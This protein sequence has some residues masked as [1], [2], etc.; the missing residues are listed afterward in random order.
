MRREAARIAAQTGDP[1]K[2]A[3]AALRLVQ[4][5]IRYVFI[6]LDGG[7]YRPQSA[8]QTWAQRFGDCKA[9]TTLL[10]ALLKELGVPAEAVLVNL[11]GGDGSNERLPSP[12]V[13]NH[14]LVRADI[15][16]KRYWMD[17]VR[18]GDVNL[19][20][21]PPPP[22]LW[23]LPI[24][25]NATLETV[26]LQIPALPLL[27]EK[28]T[29]DTSKGFDVPAGITAEHTMRGDLA[30]KLQ[31]DLAAM[32]PED[33]ERGQ[34]SYWKGEQDWVEPQ[35]VAWRYDEAQKILVLTMSGTGK[36]DWEGDATD[37]HILNI[38]GAGFTPPAEKKRPAE[39][40]QNAPWAL[41]FPRHVCF[42]T[43]I[44]LPAV[45][46]AKWRWTYRS[47]PVNR[48]LGGIRYWRQAAL[49]GDVMRTSM[50]VQAYQPELSAE[51]AK[52]FNAALPTFDNY[53]SQVYQRPANRLSTAAAAQRAAD[54]ATDW[55]ERTLPCA[56]PEDAA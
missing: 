51:E 13:F 15:G 56:P 21:V 31:A 17:G 29:V 18:E 3:E 20:S 25:A 44:R 23:A 30:Y 19:A 42:I 43:L 36:P 53:I 16:G 46:A 55:R 38:P 27:V 47:A 4:E 33:A 8:D 6:G 39:Q 45:D 12:G 5:N 40:D 14:V 50:S 10:L 32:T 26:P 41:T 37:G 9:K 7:S 28:L 54:T 52:V 49:D 11:E 48:R 1:L 24:K 35:Q 22:F 2:R 34:K